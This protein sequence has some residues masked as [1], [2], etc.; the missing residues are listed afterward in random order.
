MKVLSVLA[1]IRLDE[2]PDKIE[3]VLI[4]SLM[5]EAVAISSSKDRSSGPSSDPLASSTWEEVLYYDDRCWFGVVIMLLL[6]NI[7]INNAHKLGLCK[8]YSD[9]TCAM[10]VLVEAVQSRDRIYGYSG[11]NSTGTIF[12]CTFLRPLYFIFCLHFSDFIY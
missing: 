3:N 10:Q 4:S 12:H 2:K 8:G 6:N 1:A 9:Y 11:H 5:N 7:I